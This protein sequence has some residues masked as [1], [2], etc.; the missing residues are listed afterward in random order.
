MVIT[1]KLNGWNCLEVLSDGTSRFVSLVTGE[2]TYLVKVNAEGVGKIVLHSSSLQS[3]RIEV[4]NALSVSKKRLMAFRAK[5]LMLKKLKGDVSKTETLVADYLGGFS[6]ENNVRWNFDI[7]NN[8]HNSVNYIEYADKWSAFQEKGE[9]QALSMP[10]NFDPVVSI[11]IPT[12]GRTDL[13]YRLLLSILLQDDKSIS[14]EVIVAEDASDSGCII[15]DYVEGIKVIR[16]KINLGFLKNCNNAINQVKGEFVVLLNNDTY[17]TRDWLSELLQPFKRDSK[18][19]LVGAKLLY[20]NGD[21]QEA[22]GIVWNNGQPWNVA[23]GKDSYHC[24]YSYTREVDYLSGAVLCFRNQ[25]WQELG[26]FNECYSPAY[27]EDT[28][29]AF[30]VKAAG[31]KVVY[32]AMCK[33]VHDEGQSHGTDVTSGVKKY[34]AINSEYFKSNWQGSFKYLGKEGHQLHLNKDRGIKF[35]VLFID[36]TTPE[37]NKNAGSYAAV[38]EIKLFQSLGAKV[39]FVPENL[40]YWNEYTKDLQRIGVEAIYAPYFYRVEEFLNKRLEEFDLVYITRNEVASRYMDTIKTKSPNTPVF[41]NNADLHFLREFRQSVSENEVDLPALLASRE[42]ELD[43]INRADKTFVY[44]KEERTALE[45]HFVPNNKIVINPWVLS[46]KEKISPIAQNGICFLGGYNHLP[47]TQAVIW[48]VEN[49]MPKVVAIDPSIHF[50]IYGSNFPDDLKNK[51]K[52]FKNINVVGFVESLDTIF[53]NNRLFVAPLLSGAGVKGKVLEALSYGMP[54]IL[55]S[56]AAEGIFLVDGVN[57]SIPETPDEW[58]DS[59]VGLYHNVELL[60]QY[61]LNSYSLANSSYS[62]ENALAR[63]AEVLKDFGIT[64]DGMGL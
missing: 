48:F 32:A 19:G 16:N 55:S 9:I 14:Y 53:K 13:V 45:S 4:K 26:G 44:T 5:S 64:H 28:D 49:V 12:Y 25:V 62:F 58:C 41:F 37:P 36:A 38:Q 60:E 31:L 46:K 35:R 15:D 42:R 30:K 56:V 3:G 43:V 40:A 47:N 50:N 52:E 6:S 63:Y 1:L 22:G 54:C 2:I 24:E 8:I 29:F 10:V 61:S 23:K 51:F 11:V 27:Y 34:Q 17:V 20:P 59:I 7:E 57:C 33:I 21:I 18:T 39:T